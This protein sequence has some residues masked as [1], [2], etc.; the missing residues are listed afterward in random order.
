MKPA[1]L[2]PL[3]AYSRTSGAQ[4]LMACLQRLFG[5]AS[6]VPWKKILQLQIKDNL[7]YFSFS[8]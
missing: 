2:I 4:T 5:A 3:K 8:Y 1:E 6:G 7:G